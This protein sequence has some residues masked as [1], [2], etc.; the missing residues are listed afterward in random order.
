MARGYV[1]LHAHLDGAISVCIA[2]QLAEMQGIELP[3]ANDAELLDLLSVPDTCTSLND[4]LTCFEQPLSLL[5]TPRALREAVR[6]VAG[7]MAEEGVAYTELR[8]AP[9]LHGLDGMTQEEAVRAAIAGLEDAE[10]PANLILCCMRGAGNETANEETIELA[11]KYLVE[12]GGVVA[13]DLA[14]AEALFPTYN[15]LDL[16]GRARELGVP[17]TIHA[18]EAAGPGSVRDAL[19]MGAARVGHGVR[20][21]VDDALVDELAER[22]IPLEMCPTSNRQTCAVSNMDEY[23]LTDYLE[24]GVCVT[25]NTDD[26]AIERTTLAQEFAYAENELGAT[27]EQLDTMTENAVEAAFTSD[28]TRAELRRKLGL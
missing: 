4:F 26:K 11:S 3:A 19:K 27:P 23:P 2:K 17:Y 24:R 6:L 13:L 8:F 28:G 16:F 7:E 9:Q 20:A 22:G 18:G 10:I 5:Q 12:D 25:L 21:A 15:Y 1:D 14:G